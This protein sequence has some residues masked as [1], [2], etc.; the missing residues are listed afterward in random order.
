MKWKNMDENCTC[1]RRRDTRSSCNLSMHKL[2][3]LRRCHRCNLSHRRTWFPDERS[4]RKS[5]GNR[6]PD[7][8]NLRKG[9]SSRHFRRDNPKILKNRFFHHFHKFRHSKHLTRGKFHSRS[10]FH[11]FL[12]LETKLFD[13]VV[14]TSS[15]SL[16]VTNFR[17]RH[18]D[19]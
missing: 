6:K 14:R 2:T 10:K 19:V 17:E 3:F 18:A 7:K 13:F 11:A 9:F 12:S 1:T 15:R 16:T 5:T 4:R 8:D